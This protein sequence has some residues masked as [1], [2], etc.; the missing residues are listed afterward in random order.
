MKTKRI[1]EYYGTDSFTG[2]R[3][4]VFQFGF[5]VVVLVLFSA[6]GTSLFGIDE[7]SWILTTINWIAVCL[8]LFLARQTFWLRTLDVRVKDFN[9]LVESKEQFV[10]IWIDLYNLKEDYGEIT[11]GVRDFEASL[12][13]EFSLVEL[14]NYVS[15]WRK[16][17][18]VFSK[19]L[20]RENVTPPTFLFPANFDSIRGIARLIGSQKFSELL[21]KKALQHNVIKEISEEKN[22]GKLLIR[23]RNL[24]YIKNE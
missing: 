19:S 7:E 11:K 9:T 16:V 17:P 3:N 20:P 10:P 5:I 4:Q 18:S 13:L 12:N 2:L 21:I 6:K 15:V 8:G 22:E 1:S 24:G 23:Y 14:V